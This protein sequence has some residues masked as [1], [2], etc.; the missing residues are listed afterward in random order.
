[1]MGPAANRH[2]AFHPHKLVSAK[3]KTNVTTSV[4]V[5][6]FAIKENDSNRRLNNSRVVLSLLPAFLIITMALVIKE[7][8]YVSKKSSFIN[9]ISFIIRKQPLS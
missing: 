1:M 8:N 3:Y 6:I 7:I 9:L 4:K 2:A 5:E